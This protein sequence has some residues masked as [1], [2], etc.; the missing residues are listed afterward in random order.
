LSVNPGQPPL[1]FLS[2]GTT[3]PTRARICSPN[4]HPNQ[5]THTTT[6][7][8]A[9]RHEV[10][11]QTTPTRP[12]LSVN[13]TSRRRYLVSVGTPLPS[14]EAPYSAERQREDRAAETLHR[15][16]P[17]ADLDCE[18][19]ALSALTL[20]S[21]SLASCAIPVDATSLSP[22][23]LG[24]GWTAPS[25]LGPHLALIATVAGPAAAT[26]HPNPADVGDA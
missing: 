1:H 13:P 6:H 7:P 19:R 5:S 4:A 16:I 2:I 12:S 8:R 17:P 22:G 14:D 20:S 10:S 21:T 25:P 15:A 24:A 23:D 26:Q 9:D 18:F 3:L 11:A